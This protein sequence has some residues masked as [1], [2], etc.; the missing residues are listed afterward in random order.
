ML[1]SRRFT[2]GLLAAVLFAACAAEQ[3]AAP[4]P[5][6]PPIFG[7]DGKEAKLVLNWNPSA[8]PQNEGALWLGYL[9]ARVQYRDVHMP[10]ALYYGPQPPG[11]EEEV[12]ARDTAGQI[13][14]ELRQKERDLNVPYFNDL[15]R[16]RAAGFIREYVWV[17][18][19][20]GEWT[21]PGELRLKEFEEW[22]RA[23]LAAHRVV[24]Y[25]SISLERQ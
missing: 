14:V 19:H 10:A 25:G 22:R 5:A 21:D 23:N 3:P 8:V 16:V 12:A 15:V 18:L 17:Y 24:T 13:Y 4:R 6:R 11:F 2:V 9:L 20:R 1:R 7:P